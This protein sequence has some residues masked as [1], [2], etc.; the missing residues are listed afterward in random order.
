MSIILTS[1]LDVKHYFFKFLIVSTDVI[2]D[3][4]FI[5]QLKQIPLIWS[6]VKSQIFILI[7]LHLQV[8]QR[9]W[10]I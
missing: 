10:W 9:N 2:I 8:F 7:I 5:S 3:V 1:L 6:L 4:K